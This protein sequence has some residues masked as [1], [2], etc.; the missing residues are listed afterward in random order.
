MIHLGGICGPVK[1]SITHHIPTAGPPISGR[2]WR[3]APERLKIARDVFDHMLEFGIIRPSAS[4]WACPL[5]MVPKKSPGDWHSCGDNR[6]LNTPD[7]YPIQHIHDFPTSLYGAYNIEYQQIPVEP[8]DVPKTGI[9]TP[10]NLFQFVRLPL[11]PRHFN[12]S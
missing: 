1:H 2:T 12:V 9:M 11:P 8:S 3:L 10:L 7:R 6:A 4:S 5:H